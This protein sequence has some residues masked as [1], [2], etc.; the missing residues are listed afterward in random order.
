[1]IEQT[2][3]IE[4][5]RDIKGYEGLYQ[6]SNLG[7][8]K[9]VSK[10]VWNGYSFVKKTEKILKPGTDGHGY[11]H[12]NLSR[13]SRQRTT[14]VHRLVAKHFIENPDK[15]YTVNHINGIKKDNRADNLEWSTQ[16]ENNKHAWDSG[17]RK[18]SDEERIKKSSIRSKIVLDLF[19]GVYYNSAKEAAEYIGIKHSTLKSM[20]NGTNKNRT[21]L[22]YA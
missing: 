6:I 8:V 12:V 7:R 3:T 17:L 5:W 16:S 20:L 21:N 13:D 18:M 10:S 11:L 9:S 14:K 4:E 19:S 22:I 1:M 15:K 2:K